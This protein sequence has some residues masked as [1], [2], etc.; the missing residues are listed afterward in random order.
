MIDA[1]WPNSAVE[2]EAL[3]REL[4]NLEPPPW[5]P[6]PARGL[7]VAGVFAAS[8]T[9]LVGTG[10]A[11]DR[12]WAAAVAIDVGR[13]G[14]RV[15]AVV[16]GEAGGPYLG[17]LLALRQGALLASAI[18]AL[19]IRP[20]T[21][22]VNGTGRDHPRRAGLA[23]HLGAALDTPSVG[24]TDRPLLA[25]PMQPGIERGSAAPIVLDAEV[26]AFALRTRSGARPVF[27]HA[28]WRTDAETA[29]DLVLRSDGPART[30]EPLRL[31]RRLV[32]VSR[33][34]DEGRAPA[35]H[36]SPRPRT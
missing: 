12:L 20:D 31:A 25:M 8:A 32:R 11:G 6:D 4:A 17:G 34:R 3:Q 29:C 26:V 13:G 19:G 30:P 2:L 10:A 1:R 27:V 33:A 15:E 36:P 18:Q 22:L 5:T 28:G 16:R 23:L 9:G 35:G 14:S 21:L 7:V 24:V